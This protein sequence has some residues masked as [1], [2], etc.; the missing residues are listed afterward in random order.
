V[1]RRPQGVPIVVLSLDHLLERIYRSALPARDAS[2]PEE[3]T[4]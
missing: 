3:A 4:E 2:A 1:V